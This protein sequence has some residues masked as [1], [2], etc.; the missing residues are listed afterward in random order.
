MLETQNHYSYKVTTTGYRQIAQWMLKHYKPEVWDRL[1]TPDDVTRA[2][3]AWAE[4]A[5]KS[6]NGEIEMRSHWTQSGRI[7]Y[8]TPERELVVTPEAV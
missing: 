1:V 2:V 5:E 8:L 4:E 7:E 6:Q 3:Y